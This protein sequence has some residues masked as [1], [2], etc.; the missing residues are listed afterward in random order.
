MAT[1]AITSQPLTPAAP[2]RTPRWLHAVAVLTAVCAMPLLF[3]GAEV[4]TKQVGMVDQQGLRQPWHLYTLISDHVRQDGMRYFADPSN[5]GLLIEHTHRTFGWIVGLCSITLALGLG[6]GQKRV[7]LRWL[8]I[9]ALLTVTGQGVLGILRVNEHVRAGPELAMIHGCTAQ[10]V[11]ALL[12]AVAYLTSAA[13]EDIS[14]GIAV[15]ARL[16]RLT[17]MTA[18]LTYA[19]VVLGALVRHTESAIAPRAHLLVAFAVVAGVAAIAWAYWNS[20]EHDRRLA[21]PLGVLIALVALQ[22]FLGVE[23][24]LSKFTS[25]QWPQLKPLFPQPD[26]AR[27][28][29]LLVG[30]LL[31]AASVVMA[32]RARLGGSPLRAGHRLEEAA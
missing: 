20:S 9:V 18:S 25:G 15:D 2:H 29:H 28:L 26:L 31:F 30:S 14:A 17:F 27:S 22:L 19:Q 11:F 8:G 16:S 6:F 13:G 7:W 5:W 4:T 21:R 10:L 32:L 1:A 24:W 12:V 23:A 3:L